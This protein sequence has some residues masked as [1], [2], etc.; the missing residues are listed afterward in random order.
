MCLEKFSNILR[1]L[2]DREFDIIV[3][4]GCGDG[5]FARLSQTRFPKSMIVGLDVSRHEIKMAKSV[6][7]TFQN[8]FHVI[9]ADARYLPLRNR[10][11][12]LC[13]FFELIEHFSKGGGAKLLKELKRV[14]ASRGYLGLSTP[15]IRS[16]TS[17]TGKILY[18]VLGKK[19][20]AGNPAHI[21]IYNP[22]E[23]VQMLMSSGFSVMKSFGFWFL[24]QGIYYLDAKLRNMR[25]WQLIMQR[26]WSESKFGLLLGFDT[27]ILARL[28]R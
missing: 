14:L 7:H 4:V 10:S 8:G 18:R 15:N 25:F 27:I 3:D 5:E 20:N 21:H 6:S 17:L 28:Q 13:C 1:I 26:S 19:W 23:I 12:E 22:T 2:P 16:F 9:L 11:A 24:P